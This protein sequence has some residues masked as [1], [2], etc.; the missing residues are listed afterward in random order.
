MTM[1]DLTPIIEYFN[2]ND[3]V[4]MAFVFGSW[5]KGHAGDDSDVDVAV[6]IK[7]VEQNPE[8]EAEDL[9]SKHIQDIWAEMERMT[10]REVDLIVLNDAAPTI[11][12]SALQGIPVVIKDRMLYLDFLLR[13]SG[14]AAD[15]REWAESFWTIKQGYIHETSA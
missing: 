9:F 6:Y 15:Y 7:R 14:E 11:A 5:A 2:S 4:L 1:Q 10:G 13:V 12:A 3:R 8:G